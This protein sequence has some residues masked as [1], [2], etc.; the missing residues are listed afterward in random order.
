MKTSMEDEVAPTRPKISRMSG[1]TTTRKKHVPM[2]PSM[3]AMCQ[4]HEKSVTASLLG[5]EF[6]LK[7][8][9]GGKDN[10]A[11]KITALRAGKWT[12]GSVR[13]TPMMTQARTIR[14]ST[15]EGSV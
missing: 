8:V 4:A 15:F 14:V 13:M 11:R 10:L 12:M 7:F 3:T 2:R 1:T 6:H 5:L 9:I